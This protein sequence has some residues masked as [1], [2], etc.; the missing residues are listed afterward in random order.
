MAE[1][2]RALANGP[3]GLYNGRN[4]FCHFDRMI[5]C[6]PLRRL[7]SPRLFRLA[8]AIAFFNTGYSIYLF[9]FNFFISSQGRDEHWMG[10]LHGAMIFGSVLGALP[11][12]YLANRFGLRPTLASSLLLSGILLAFRTHV[13]ATTAQVL[14]ACLSGLFLSGW[15][16]LI[17]PAMAALVK[18]DNR[19][20]VFPW[21]CGLGVGCGCLGALAGGWLPTLLP[22]FCLQS[23]QTGLLLGAALISFSSLL[24]PAD[25]PSETVAKLMPVQKSYW[26]ILLASAL[27]SFAMSGFNPFA[28]IFFFSRFQLP[29]TSIGNLFFAVQM[30]T[31]LALVLWG[32]LAV[33]RFSPLPLLCSLQL[34]AGALLAFMAL[35][36]LAP[37]IAS[38]L[39]L[40][41]AQQLAQPAL[42]AL[43]METPAI[44]VRNSVAAW[45]ALGCAL[46][47]AIATPLSGFF[48]RSYGYERTLPFLGLIAALTA[49]LWPLISI[50]QRRRSLDAS[51]KSAA[52][53]I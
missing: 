32:S 15:T 40:M 38:Y 13:V 4:I 9:L 14:L 29:L 48:Y 12:G 33:R 10:I 17:F 18:P 20:A 25:Q 3:A 53:S 34:I 11:A 7:L 21:L 35:P 23:H 36:F 47:Q 51:R 30:F 6:H 28:G 45:N 31:A 50:R 19:P 39:L 8:F 49:L 52:Q 41:L 5:R 37:A 16:V 44:E 1:R 27:F 22:L 24:L 26:P 46:A 43:Y 42:Q 2:Q